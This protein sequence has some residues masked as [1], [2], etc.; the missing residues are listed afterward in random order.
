M[1][2]PVLVAHFERRSEL[3][4]IVRAALEVDIV[5]VSLP[6]KPAGGRHTLQLWVGPELV[7]S[8]SA[9]M[10]GSGRP[11]GEYPLRVRP[12]EEAQRIELEALAA[13]PAEVRSSGS[14]PVARP[15]RVSVRQEEPAASPSGPNDDPDVRPRR[16]SVRR[17]SQEMEAARASRTPSVR[18]EATSEDRTL[19]SR[20]APP[21]PPAP[22]GS[23]CGRGN[24]G[25]WAG[26]LPKP[27]RAQRN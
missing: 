15:R 13:R 26:V 5:Y 2:Q 17:A 10:V 7:C 23:P 19:A 20:A 11:G 14:I 3:A 16:S 18:S 1:A 22:A 25:V 6:E 8:V 4:P 24:H 9:E 27:R 21:N 12:L